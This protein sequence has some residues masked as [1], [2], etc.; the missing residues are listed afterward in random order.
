[1]MGGYERRIN[2]MGLLRYEELGLNWVNLNLPFY[3]DVKRRQSKLA[4]FLVSTDL[5]LIAKGF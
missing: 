1:M 5:E 2:M 3:H 4:L